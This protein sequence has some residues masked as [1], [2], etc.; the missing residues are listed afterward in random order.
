MSE[1]GRGNER[2]QF[3][4]KSVVGL[5]GVTFFPPVLQDDTKTQSQETKSKR[6]FRTRKLGKT[7]LELP[8]VS[9]GV[10]NAD[11]PNLVRG[12]LDAGMVHL[13][14]AHAYQG[15]R[16]EEMIGEVIKDFPRDS[17][18]IATKVAGEPV[19]RK[20]GLFTE[21]AKAEPFLEKFEISLK[22]LGLEYVD[23]LY[24]HSIVRREATLYEPYVTA[25]Q[26]LKTEGKIRFIGVS[27]HRSEPE[28]IKAAV[29]SKVYDVVLTAYNFR[30]PH[31]AEMEKAMAEATQAG[32][33]IVAMKTQAG[34][35]W[36][37]ERQRKINMK[38]ALKWVLQN[39]N[40]HTTIPGFTT[41]DQME[42]DLAVMEDISLTV[43][44]KKALQL[45]E[46]T[47]MN[48]LYC[49]QCEVCLS[50]CPKDLDIPTFM[51]SYMY[52]HGYR[53]LRAAKEALAFAHQAD[54][55]CNSCETCAVS[56]PSGFN[57]K[58]RILDIAR[59][60]DI[61]DDFVV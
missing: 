45:G 21:D 53:N 19:D 22:R 13:D 18:V 3:L 33:G 8:V 59:V 34:V 7:G 61:P 1:C 60:K 31:L 23:I 47:G 9:M 41:F 56:C 32:L 36:D 39:E 35:Y 55:S 46:K 38:A 14:T 48:G 43:E 4:K 44:E 40:V 20:T 30:Q 51:R 58:Y 16:N 2:R 25:M 49:S 54:V 37:E 6:T 24:L 11:N 42:E 28:V 15:G 26:K 10:M 17:Y 52:A 27:T 12:A 29:D 5:A 57:V 50:Q